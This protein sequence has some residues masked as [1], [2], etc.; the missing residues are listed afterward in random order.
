MRHFDDIA[1][2]RYI[3]AALST[4]VSCR[5]GEKRACCPRCGARVY[6]TEEF[7][8]G[9]QS[10][11]RGCAKC[12]TCARQLDFNSVY[13]GADKDIYCKGCYGRKFGTAGFRGIISR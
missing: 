4:F 8:S 10:Y 2:G 11:H 5:E 1:A 13:D 6:K 9:G 3:T 12:A 7:C